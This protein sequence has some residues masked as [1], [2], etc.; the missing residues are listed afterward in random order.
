MN[1]DSEDTQIKQSARA[2]DGLDM[3]TSALSEENLC[4]YQ[5]YDIFETPVKQKGSDTEKCWL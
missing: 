2:S 3:K 1:S 5:V 4:Q